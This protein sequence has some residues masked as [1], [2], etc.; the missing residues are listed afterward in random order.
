VFQAAGTTTG[1]AAECLERLVAPTDRVLLGTAAG[2]ALTLQSALLEQRERLAG[3]RLS[4]G[5]QLGSYAFMAA[6]RDGAWRYDT[7]HVMPSI[8]DDV[9][10]GI[11]G[12]HPVRG[13]AVPALIRRLDPDVFLTSVSTPDRD[14]SVSL[15]ASV[16]YAL[17]AIEHVPRTIAEINPDMPRTRG[18][19]RVALDRF[20]AVVEA[21]QPLPVHVARERSAESEAIAMHVRD[22]I[23]DGATVQIGLGGIP[24]ALLESW[25]HDPPPGLRLFGMGIDGMIELVTRLDYPGA[26]VGGELLGSK[27]LYSFA[28]DNP[29]VEQYPISEILSVP[30]LASMPRFVSVTS[31][32]EVDLGGQINAEWAAGQQI[33]GPGGGFDF[34]DAAGMSDGGF[35]IVAL[36]STSRQGAV[37]AIVP[38][39]SAGAPVTTPRHTAQIVV[40][41][42]GVA[43]LRGLTLVERAQALVGIAAPACRAQLVEASPAGHGVAQSERRAQ[44]ARG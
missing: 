4:S 17:P 21:E 37:S 38:R 25:T 44:T 43:D 31:A 33:S 2:A 7:W 11:V 34:I 27:S 14:G 32:V 39:L 9:A 29:L 20:A 8:R 5:L 10:R 24:E 23:P 16:S 6:V 1:S 22:L 36:P 26:Y 18:Q 28:D 40:T 19:T 41:E 12:L 35:A 15:G 42:H 30:R 3:L 13:A